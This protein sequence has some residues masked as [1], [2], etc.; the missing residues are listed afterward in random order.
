MT[1]VTIKLEKAKKKSEAREY[2]SEL[3]KD[4]KWFKEISEMMAAGSEIYLAKLK[5][6]DEN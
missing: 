6:L 4:E 3:T 5:K 2:F 1:A